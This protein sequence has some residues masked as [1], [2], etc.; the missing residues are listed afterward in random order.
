VK[1]PEPLAPLVAQLLHD[2][3]IFQNLDDALTAKKKHSEIAAATLEWR[4][5][6][7]R[8]SCVWWE[9]GNISRFSTRTQSANVGPGQG[10]FEIRSNATL[11]LKNATMPERRWKKRAA[12]W[13][14]PVEITK[15]GT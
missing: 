3:A 5:D 8:G 12:S 14:K 4:I 15:R 2:V 13:K 7:D 6:F 10:V 1:A 9:P 11:C